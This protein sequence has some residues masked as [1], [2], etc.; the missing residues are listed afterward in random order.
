M[1][2]RRPDSRAPAKLRLHTQRV[3]ERLH[4]ISV[5]GCDRT[6]TDRSGWAAKLIRKDRAP[7]DRHRWRLSDTLARRLPGRTASKRPLRSRR[8]RFR[9]PGSTSRFSGR[10]S[11]V[12]VALYCSINRTSRHQ[13]VAMSRTGRRIEVNQHRRSSERPAVLLVVFHAVHG[14]GLPS[15][16]MLP[17]YRPAGRLLLVGTSA[18]RE[19]SPQSQANA[20]LESYRPT[21]A[22]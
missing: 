15:G 20:I 3:E 10:R 5:R 8:S 21:A 12:N 19:P 6:E 18:C 22:G 7:E 2:R 16:K 4:L 13:P 11:R 14:H 17:V 9:Y 1:L